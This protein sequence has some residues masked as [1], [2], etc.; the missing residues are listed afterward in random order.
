MGVSLQRTGCGT[1][2]EE[3]RDEN[4]GI[5]IDGPPHRPAKVEEKPDRGRL[6]PPLPRVDATKQSP[7][8]T[9][10]FCRAAKPI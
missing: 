10:P 3:C 5:D 6:V 1:S 8:Q 2:A 4:P 7:S 9:K